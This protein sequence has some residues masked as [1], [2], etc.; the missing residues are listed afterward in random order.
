[1]KCS[2]FIATST[3]GYIA[4]EN[5]GLDWLH[6]SGDL[7][8]DMTGNPDMGFSDYINS[9]DCM[10]MGRKCME[11]ISSF[12]LTPEQWPYGDIKIYVL[13]HTLTV[14][15]ENLSSKVEMYSG[16][17]S[18]LVCRLE[19]DGYK[20]AY[21]DGGTTITSFLNKQLINEVTI[22]KVPV[23]LGG[24]IPLFG[25][26]ERAV[27]LTDASA[28]VFPNDYMQIRYGVKYA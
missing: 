4:E 22:T 23:V 7:D 19:Q 10:I 11:M 12:N 25:R 24:G 1:M 6:T 14:A 17:V 16:D 28:I 13:S 8:A 5:G 9:V 15:P 27:Q 3:D 18:D 20:H 2:V 21:I 26:L